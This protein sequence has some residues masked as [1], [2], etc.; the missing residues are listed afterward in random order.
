VEFDNNDVCTLLLSHFVKF[1]SANAVQHRKA[2]REDSPSHAIEDSERQR[3][4]SSEFKDN[5]LSR[6][7]AEAG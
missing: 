7:G 6:M 3:L 1:T 4:R 2:C 5:S